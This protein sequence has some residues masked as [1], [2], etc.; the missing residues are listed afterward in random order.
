MKPNLTHVRYEESEFIVKNQFHNWTSE[1][2]CIW[3]TF[4]KLGYFWLFLSSS[5]DSIWFLTSNMNQ[6]CFH[7][8]WLFFSSIILSFEQCM[9]VVS[10]ERQECFLLAKVDDCGFLLGFQ[11]EFWLEIQPQ[12]VC[13]IFFHHNAMPPL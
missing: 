13:C 11:S 5:I 1:L 6:I 4:G 12:L 8:Q 7:F 2:G 3:H 9:N 10:S